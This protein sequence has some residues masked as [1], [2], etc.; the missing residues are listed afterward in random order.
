MLGLR[1]D[2]GVCQSLLTNLLHYV[3]VQAELLTLMLDKLADL[4]LLHF[5]PLAWQVSQKA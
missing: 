5:C 1:G 2:L 3:H 4:L